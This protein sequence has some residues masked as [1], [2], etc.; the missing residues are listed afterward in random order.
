MSIVCHPELDLLASFAYSGSSKPGG[1]A[2]GSG[3]G[4]E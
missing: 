4:S 3:A 1:L 2:T